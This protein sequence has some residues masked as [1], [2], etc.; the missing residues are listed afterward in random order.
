MAITKTQDL[1]AYEVGHLYDAEHRFL[2]SQQ[3][4]VRKA[5][6]HNLEK[7]L[8]E[9][10][11][12]TRLHIRNLEQV[13]GM[14]GQQPRRQTSHVAQWLVNEARQSIQQAQSEDI[15]DCAINVA[16]IK[17]EH[18]EM[19]SYRGMVTGAQLMGRSEMA[20]LLD[21]NMRQEEETARIAERSMGD[22]LRNVQQA[23]K[24]AGGLMDKVKEVKDRLTGQ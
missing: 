2:E 12:Q 7:A 17:V 22:L 16:V 20:D 24:E 18:F 6:D 9:H 13:F 15:R 1:L 21:Q 4:M 8:Q 23:E 5:T 14:L 11:E 19:G 3:E 10:I